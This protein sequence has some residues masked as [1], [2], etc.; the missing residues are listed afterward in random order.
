MCRCLIGFASSVQRV[1][2]F[3]TVVI[4]L[5]LQ[6][7]PVM[8]QAP[9]VTIPV[10]FSNIALDG[11][12]NSNGNAVTTTVSAVRKLGAWTVEV[13]NVGLHVKDFTTPSGLGNVVDLN[14]SRS[15]TLMQAIDSIGG[16]IYTVTFRMSGNWTTNA[17]G[18]RTLTVA[19]G[20]APV[21]FTVGRPVGW[22]RANPQW[23]L[24][25]ATFIGTGGRVALRFASGNTGADGA[26]IT[27]VQVAGPLALPA[28]LN[29]VPV[30]TPPN[31]ADFV[32]DPKVAIVLGKAFFWDMQVGSDARTSCATC[33]WH[34]GADVRTGNMFHPGA[35]G[36]AFGP[37]RADS[38]ALNSLAVARFLGAARGMSAAD[39]PFHKVTSP[40][41][42]RDP[43]RNPVISD[44]M[45]VV[46]SEGVTSKN[47]L[48]ATPGVAAEAGLTVA[49]QLFE[50]GAA[51]LRQTTARNS[52][53]TIN[54]AFLDRSFWDGRANRFF[55][56]V[57]EFGDLD[58]D[59][60]VLRAAPDGTVSPV[61]ILLDNGTL[62][63]QAVGPVRSHVEM[64][65]LGRSFPE[66]GR[67][68]F[69]LR[70]LAQQRVAVDDSVLAAYRDASG[71]GLD[72]GTASYAALIRGA[73][74]P[75]WWS[76][77]Q[78]TPAG[79]TQ[80]EANFALFWG[81]S[82]MMYEATLV[83][84]Q[85]PY[86]R[87][88]A[89]DATAL[90]DEARIGLSI[91]LQEGRCFGCHIG[92]EFA[93]SAVSTVRPVIGPL[94]LIENM[95]M[96]QGTAFYDVGFYNIG[97]RNTA[98]D[99]G[100]GASHPQFGALSYVRQAAAGRIRDPRFVIGPRSRVAVDG[101]FKTPSLR[102]VELTGPYMHNGGM[103]SL[104]EIV[105]FYTRGADFFQENIR[106]LAPGVQG[107][108]VLQ[109]NP[110]GV[111]AVVEFLKHLTDER[112]RFQSAPFDHPELL[113]PNGPGQITANVALDNLVRLPETGKSGGTPFTNFETV[114]TKGLG[115]P[116]PIVDAP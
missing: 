104:T 91:F 27:D 13:G 35:P 67:K 56:G 71:K 31:L 81:I 53:T 110:A 43:V 96:M 5:S 90:T 113:L 69:S 4:G 84:D 87:F 109:N 107:I 99:L 25:T 23:V 41:L 48:G 89:G 54:A 106:D 7:N 72:A 30:P 78:I 52:P 45:E 29:T 51:S 63:S 100:I 74:R 93:G 95:G 50:R 47:F 33:H 24:Q 64:S 102:N 75:E 61:R 2:S 76:G 44:S 79:C 26:I 57:N 83:S 94:A 37:Q 8:A 60:R 16:A 22:T 114:L 98:E 39:F 59:A 49:N 62:A 15:G 20:G 116:A 112:V 73:F 36:S 101:A 97:V 28:P 19:M 38:A 111:A 85:S 58:P 77:T 68:L 32:Q 92:P 6:A 108:P 14:G 11:L 42:A 1:V 70:P 18:T 88:A 115:L 46:G 80:M 9:P 34:A 86:D 12:F 17:A 66:V 105:E 3:C 82:V 40:L 55:N 21:S 103:K 65:W 10:A